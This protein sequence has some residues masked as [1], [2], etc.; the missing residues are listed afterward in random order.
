MPAKR[1]CL[2]VGF[3][4]LFEGLPAG[5]VLVLAGG[6]VHGEFGGAADETGFEHEGQGAV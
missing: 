3:E 6:G 4:V 5:V 2:W 1:A